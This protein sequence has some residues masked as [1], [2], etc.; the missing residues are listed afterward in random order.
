MT[1]FVV[2][3]LGIIAMVVSLTG[4]AIFGGGAS[5][6]G[7]SVTAN[8]K[9]QLVMG[10]GKWTGP[11]DCSAVA[12]LKKTDDALII[13]VNVKDD[14]LSSSADEPYNQDSVELYFDVRPGKSRGKSYYSKGVFQMIVP[15]PEKDGE[16]NIKWYQG[17]GESPYAEIP[18]TKAVYAK[19]ADG[20]TLTVTLP[21]KGFEEVHYPLGKDFN[22]AFGVND[23]DKDGVRTQIT[24]AGTCEN[25]C[26]PSGFATIA[27]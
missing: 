5:I 16:A 9:D 26:D 22:F 24:S 25:Y 13:S 27:L 6:G 19:T 12:T 10:R 17:D 15:I 8:T 21:L 20:Y 1:K 7:I 2:G 14:Y 18:N 11:S 23:L 4:C 3:L